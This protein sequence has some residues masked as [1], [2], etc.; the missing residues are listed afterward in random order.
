MNY[1]DYGYNYYNKVSAANSIFA[2]LGTYML[3]WF[4]ILIF[5]IICMWKIFKKA[6]KN[7]WEAIIPIYNIIVLLQIVELPIW[8][9]V[10]FVIPFANVY[11]IFKIYIELAHK[12]GKSTSFG[13]AMVFFGI[14]C[15]PILAFGNS[16][17]NNNNGINYHQNQS[18]NIQTSQQYNQI[19]NNNQN[20][21]MLQQNIKVCPNCGNKVDANATACFM[22]GNKF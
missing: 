11:V 9:I 13:V 20:Q 22:C 5:M 14:I 16:S 17:Y 12:F 8:Y 4:I 3:F 21:S 15:F 18:N 7:G 19:N 6:G 1:Y 10:L 2:I